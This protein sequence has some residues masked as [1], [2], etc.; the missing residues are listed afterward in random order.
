MT[1]RIRWSFSWLGS[2]I[3]VGPTL[4]DSVA[5]E[6]VVRMGG[7][8]IMRGAVVVGVEMRRGVG[9]FRRRRIK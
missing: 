9:L 1:T 3:K 4:G 5:E 7:K 2:G 6:G 8:G